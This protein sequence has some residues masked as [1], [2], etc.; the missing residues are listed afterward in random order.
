[1]MLVRLSPLL[2]A[3]VALF[4]VPQPGF[5]APAPVSS[6]EQTAV[7]RTAEGRADIGAAVACFRA[8][9]RM[10]SFAHIAI[11]PDAGEA[12]YRLRFDGLMFESIRFV[13]TATGTRAEIRLAASLSRAERA[14]FEAARGASLARCL[15][16][17]TTLVDGTQTGTEIGL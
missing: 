9:A 13:R 15:D 3:G 17:P 14:H 5:A 12:V 1:M 6:F 16:R 11:Y 10:P 4:A 8:E 7:I 2:A